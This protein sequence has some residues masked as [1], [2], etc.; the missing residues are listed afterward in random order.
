M[1]AAA[2]L[3]IA[4]ITLAHVRADD[5]ATRPPPAPR[6]RVQPEAEEVELNTI[7]GKSV[8]GRTQTVEAQ[9]LRRISYAIQTRCDQARKA[10]HDDTTMGTKLSIDV[11]IDLETGHIDVVDIVG[12]LS[13]STKAII[14]KSA[15]ECSGLIP[16]PD[17]IKQTHGRTIG[18][19]VNFVI[20]P[21]SDQD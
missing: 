18:A 4:T 9:F 8:V 21:D 6:E 5:S 16:I 11:R 17:E 20:M 10:A 3:L 12:D 2:V 7:H 19:V 14:R 1:K 15:E 13:V